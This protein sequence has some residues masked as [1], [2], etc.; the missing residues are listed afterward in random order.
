M[1]RV[2]ECLQLF[3]RPGHARCI[4]RRL[5]RQSA[6]RGVRRLQLLQAA[7]STGVWRAVVLQSSCDHVA[8]H[9]RD[10]RPAITN[11]GLRNGPLRPLR[12]PDPGSRC[13]SACG[14]QGVG[15]WLL[16]GEDRT[17]CKV[18]VTALRRGVPSPP[19][20]PQLTASW[21]WMSKRAR[22]TGPVLFSACRASDLSGAFCGSKRSWPRRGTC[23]PADGKRVDRLPCGVSARPECGACARGIY[24]IF[25]RVSP[26]GAC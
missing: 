3:A 16:P 22:L 12:R 18:P 5:F 6:S 2:R 9:T 15:L 1:P 21:V 19:A 17:T 23:F 11:R 7:S 25:R 4:A 14:P 24:L 20:R 26:V 10:D 13:N 8:E